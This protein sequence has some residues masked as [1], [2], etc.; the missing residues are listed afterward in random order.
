[1][2]ICIHHSFGGCRTA[3]CRSLVIPMIG[4]GCPL[5]IRSIAE[6]CGIQWNFVWARVLLWMSWQTNARGF[7]F[8]RLQA[9]LIEGVI[10]VIAEDPNVFF[11]FAIPLTIAVLASISAKKSGVSNTKQHHPVDLRAFKN[12]PNCAEQVPLSTLAC[13]AC[14]YN[15]LSGSNGPRH[16][17]LP[18][19]DTGRLTA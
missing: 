8:I 1:M 14:E 9:R 2:L 13:D 19:P 3:D 17:L 15:F 4:A 10:L 7:G 18:S 6:C 16:K 12:C 5:M 11:L